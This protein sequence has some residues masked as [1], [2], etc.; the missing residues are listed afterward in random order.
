MKLAR[1]GVIVGL[2]MWLLVGCSSKQAALHHG[3]LVSLDSEADIRERFA[4]LKCE[5]KVSALLTSNAHWI[6]VSAYPYRS[7]DK[8]DVY[9]FEHPRDGA[10]GLKYGYYLRGVLVVPYSDTMI[11]QA[12]ET[13]GGCG[14]QH[15]GS[16]FSW[17]DHIS[18]RR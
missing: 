10:A 13:R 9:V 2:S 12:I 15:D 3:G 7:L 6:V 16:L 1:M 18:L 8:F 11:V 17:F 14:I 4:S 5:W